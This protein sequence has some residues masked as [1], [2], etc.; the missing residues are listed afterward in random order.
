MGNL[1]ISE[2]LIPRVEAILKEK[3]EQQSFSYIRNK[4][5]EQIDELEKELKNWIFTD[6]ISKTNTTLL[7]LSD[8]RVK[9]KELYKV[10]D[11]IMEENLN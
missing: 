10:Y 4:L 9:G 1:I 11:L 8:V 2:Q 6:V 3:I 5:E 7:I